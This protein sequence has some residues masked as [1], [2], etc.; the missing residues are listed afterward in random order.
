[1]T[2]K[3]PREFYEQN[4][5][6]I[7]ESYVEFLKSKSDENG[8]LKDQAN[9]ALTTIAEKFQNNEY[10]QADNAVYSLYHD[11]RL[12][13]TILIHYYSQ[14]TRSYQ[15]VDKFYK[16][17]VELLLRECYRVGASSIRDFEKPED[18]PE[19]SDFYKIVSDDFLKISK[20]YQLPITEAYHVRAK[21]GHLFTSVINRSMLDQRPKELPHQDFDVLK[22]IPQVNSQPS[23]RLGFLTVNTSNVPDPTV[24]PTEIMT[25]FLHPNWY[26]L[27]TTVWLGYGDFQSFAPS[28][29]EYKSVTDASHKGAIWL[30]KIGYKEWYD[31]NTSKE[32]PKEVEESAKSEPFEKKNTEVSEKEEEVKEEVTE[33]SSE[34]VT[35]EAPLQTDINLKNLYDWTPSNR[36]DEDEIEAFK[37]GTQQKLLSDVLLKLKEMKSSRVKLNKVNKPTFKERELYYKAQRILKESILLKQIQKPPRL[38]E[39]HFPVL[40]ANYSGSIPV[41]KSMPTRKKKHK[42]ML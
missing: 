30:E 3:F 37:N 26:P 11:I 4:P 2:E 5:N 14:G 17:A 6:M 32:T 33:K 40:Q 10:Q 21:E 38:Y 29:A 20:V 28:I 35:T 39:K 42:K 13:C 12:V 16:F 19:E 7:Y 8:A 18:E 27:P 24:P 22:I 25:S 34:L 23:N 36:I 41:L 15:M 1:M 9:L 31:L